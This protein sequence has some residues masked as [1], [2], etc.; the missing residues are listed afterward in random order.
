MTKE[1]LAGIIEHELN[2]YHLDTTYTLQLWDIAHE[3]ANVLWPYFEASQE[4]SL[5]AE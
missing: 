1:K 4:A 5:K 2:N 3:I